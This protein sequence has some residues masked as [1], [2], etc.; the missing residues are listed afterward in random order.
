MQKGFKD[1][2]AF[3]YITSFTVF[4]TLRTVAKFNCPLLHLVLKMQCSPPFVRDG[5][6]YVALRVNGQ[7]FMLHQIRK[8]IGLIG[9]SAFAIL[10]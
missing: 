5:V 3:R 4:P 10:F 6:E 1:P 9:L 2:S 7:S 8:M